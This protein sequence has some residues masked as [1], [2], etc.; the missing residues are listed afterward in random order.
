MKTL[1]SLLFVLLLTTGSAT[2]QSLLKPYILG[3]ETTG[4]VAE[5]KSKIEAGLQ[6]QGLKLLGQY[7]PGDD[8]SR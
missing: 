3:L 4:P 7:Q 1:Y 8:M 2:G 5:I 6:S